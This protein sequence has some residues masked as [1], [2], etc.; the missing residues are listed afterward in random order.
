[1]DATLL[2][3]AEE[4]LQSVIPDDVVALLA[5]EGRTAGDLVRL[6]HEIRTYYEVTDRNAIRTLK[7]AHI[8][9]AR[10]NEVDSPEPFYLAFARTKDRR[11]STVV[12]WIL[13]KPA[14]GAHAYDLERYVREFHG[15]TAA[16]GACPPRV[17]IADPVVAEE[18][19]VHAKFG[20]GKVMQRRDGKVTVAFADATRVLA[21]RFVTPE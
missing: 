8:A 6:T 13:R 4:H 3:D 2:Q 14:P 12:E 10:L 1:L 17:L 19:V 5:I 21:E 16:T 18:F 15:V 11:A 9:A 20:R 7:F